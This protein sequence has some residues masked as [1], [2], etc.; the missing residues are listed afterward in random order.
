[1]KITGIKT[2]LCFNGYNNYLFVKIETDDGISGVGEGTCTGK[3][4]SIEAS[5][6]EFERHLIGKD[7]GLIEHHYQSL[8]RGAFWRGGIVSMSALSAL[9]QALWD[10][11][12]KKLGVPVHELL[13]GKVRD[14]VRCYTRFAGFAGETPEEL[15]ADAVR[16]AKSGWTALKTAPIGHFREAGVLR[17]EHIETAAERL[18]AVREAIGSSVDILIDNH[19]RFSAPEA[20][21]LGKRLEGFGLFFFEEPVPPED[22]DGLARVAASLSIPVATGER[23]LSRHEVKPI[24]EKNAAA[25]LQSDVCHAGGISELRRIAAPWPRL[26]E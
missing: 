5:V 13:G 15:A 25:I 18:R 10:I 23:T 1:M 26:T 14:K 21:A 19:G 4:K 7:P 24:L 11:K 16:L 22:L 9:D 17:T 20:I 6:K 12:G 8:T 3:S 2:F